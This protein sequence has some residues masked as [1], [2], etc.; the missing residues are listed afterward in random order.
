MDSIE[1]WPAWTCAASRSCRGLAQLAQARVPQL[2]TGRVSKPGPAPGA[3]KNLIQPR[4]G[5]RPT[6]AA[7]LE[8]GEHRIGGRR[9]GRS[10]SRYALTR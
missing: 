5:Q 8:H 2:V 3:V 7:A 6:T 1:A 4:R 9:A 10:A